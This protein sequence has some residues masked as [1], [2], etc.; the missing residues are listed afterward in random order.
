L[1][2]RNLGCAVDP[3]EAK[4]GG[5]YD[6]NKNGDDH[7]LA[8]EIN[9]PAVKCLHYERYNGI[10]NGDVQRVEEWLVELDWVAETVYKPVERVRC[11]HDGL[12]DVEESEHINCTGMKM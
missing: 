10:E 7:P 1:G 6:E 11:D 9:P 4:Q 3:H 8:E 2:Q 5:T 12:H